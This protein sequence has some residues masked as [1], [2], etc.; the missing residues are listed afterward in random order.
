MIIVFSGFLKGKIPRATVLWSS[1]ALLSL[2]TCESEM[3][4]ELTGKWLFFDGASLSP[5][6]SK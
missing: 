1:E 6:R 4:N 3:L 2:M 5:D